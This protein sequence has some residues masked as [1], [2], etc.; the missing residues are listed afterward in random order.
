METAN[1]HDM[2]ETDEDT[3]VAVTRDGRVYLGKMSKTSVQKSKIPG[4]YTTRLLLW[5]GKAWSFLR[6]PGAAKK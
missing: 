1:S 6:L 2:K 4:K 3:V 5:I